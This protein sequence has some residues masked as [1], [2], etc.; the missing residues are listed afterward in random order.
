MVWD[1]VNGS[2]LQ[3]AK[4][5]ASMT[6]VTSRGELKGGADGIRADIDGNIWAG[7][8]WAGEGFDG[9]D[10]FAPDGTRIGQILLP[11]IASNICFGGR[12]GLP[13]HLPPGSGRGFR[14]GR[15]RCQD[16]HTDT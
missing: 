16:R 11:E 9:V 10:I 5:F 12:S 14:T 6:L 3:G 4:V 8:G 13:G 7:A 15:V 2:K 1:V